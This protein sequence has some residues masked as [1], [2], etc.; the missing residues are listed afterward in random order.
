MRSLRQATDETQ[1]QFADRAQLD[2]GFVG[3][4][5]R[6]ERNV[7][8]RKVRALLLGHGIN[9][10]EFGRLMQ[11]ADPLPRL[12]PMDR[13]ANLIQFRTALERASGNSIRGRRR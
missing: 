4:V 11:R 12:A 5:E 1:E 13:I 7:G 9:W 3:A 2:R 8:H 10:E 6:G